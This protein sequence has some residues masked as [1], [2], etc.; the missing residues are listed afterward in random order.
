MI[1]EDI[2]TSIVKVLCHLA[3]LTFCMRISSKTNTVCTYAALEIKY[4]IRTTAFVFIFVSTII[5]A[6]EMVPDVSKA[7][8]TAYFAALLEQMN[9][10]GD[11]D[12]NNHN[13]DNTEDNRRMP[14]HEGQVLQDIQGRLREKHVRNGTIRPKTISIIRDDDRQDPLVENR[15]SAP[16]SSV[17]AGN[18]RRGRRRLGSNPRSITHGETRPD[19]DASIKS[20]VVYSFRSGEGE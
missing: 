20:R 13:V 17:T 5:F 4:L 10:D 16:A 12:E 6:V 2:V 15:A 18:A 11:D 19:N 7:N 8:L 3:V 1:L 14:A 9:D